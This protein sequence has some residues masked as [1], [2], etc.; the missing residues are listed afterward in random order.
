MIEARFSGRQNPAYKAASRCRDAL[1]QLVIVR[2]PPILPPLKHTAKPFIAA[3]ILLLA[4]CQ[5]SRYTAPFQPA[6]LQYR[7]YPS[8][9][10]LLLLARS[11]A[12]EVNSHSDG[13]N[14]A[15][16]VYADFGIALARLGFAAEANAM[17]NNEILLYPSAKKY[18]TQLRANFTPSL[19]S[20]T[21]TAF[22][23][24]DTSKLDTLIVRNTP[25]P[26]ETL[27]SSALLSAPS[28]FTAGKKK[29]AASV[30]EAQAKAKEEAKAKAKE[31]KARA[32]EEAKA[33]KARAKEEAKAEKE[34]AKAEAK[35]K[36]DEAKAK[37]DAKAKAKEEKEKAKV[38]KAKAREEAKAKAKAEKAKAREEA[39]AKAK[40]E[41][42]KAKAKKETQPT[43]PT[44]DED[45]ESLEN[46]IEN[47]EDEILE[48]AE[49]ALDPID[50]DTEPSDEEPE[51]AEDVNDAED[52]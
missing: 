24:Y 48:P 26:V 23:P 14:V 37:E 27:D 33:E 21:S 25:K 1:F 5:F 44:D 8:Y 28:N 38:E 4:S 41:R 13:H 36:A 47:Y 34:R 51:P 43:Q 42:E 29:E 18:V 20:D 52:K 22:G 46:A 10:N 35:A 15:S 49:D 32:K 16:G 45:F 2:R 30:K 17:F 31:E 50:E 9:L 6:L 3:L 19:L 39:K 7:E 40:A 12:D 11:Y